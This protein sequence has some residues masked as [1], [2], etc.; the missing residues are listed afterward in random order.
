MKNEKY[1][2]KNFLKLNFFI[3]TVYFYLLISPI[4]NECTKTRPIL[5]SNGSCVLDYCSDEDYEN[6]TCI[7]SN[8]IIKTQWLSNIIKIG[9]KDFRYVNFATYSNGSMIVETTAY[10]G[11]KYGYFFGLKSNG[12]PFFENSNH[13]SIEVNDQPG[14]EN[15]YRFEAENFAA[16]IDDNQYLGE[17]YL[18]SIPKGS[19][20]SEMFMFDDDKTIKQKKSTEILDIERSDDNYRGSVSK[21]TL[22]GQIHYIFAF[23]S[24]EGFVVKRFRFKKPEFDFENEEKKTDG[25]T[26]NIGGE[27]S[28]F[29]TE[30]SKTIICVYIAIN[31][32]NT[33]YYQNYLCQIALNTDLTEKNFETYFN[34]YN[35]YTGYT[36]YTSLYGVN[37]DKNSFVKAIHLKGEVGAVIFYGIN[38]NYYYYNYDSHNNYNYYNNYNNYIIYIS[39]PI[40]ML[41][42]FNITTNTFEDYFPSIP[43]IELNK[44]SNVDLFSD[45]LIRSFFKQ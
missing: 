2:A 25:K 1:D 31:T 33:N 42:K 43:Y 15:R 9:D 37:S 5:L 19:Q 4:K 34:S 12:L 30:E 22:D 6:K 17:E 18:V 27:V 11:N 39:H 38:Y 45:T 13:Y 40:L 29:V 41:K 36:S 44:Y 10:P 23:K 14:N 3:I 20:Y 35:S 16:I 24:S 26:G 7:I 32:I 21:L 28:C 8:E